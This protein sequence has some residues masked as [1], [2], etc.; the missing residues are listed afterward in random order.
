MNVTLSLGIG[1]P[2]T[3]HLAL[4][5][6]TPSNSFPPLDLGGHLG[7]AKNDKSLH[8]TLHSFVLMS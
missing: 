8:F 3:N 1:I 4:K 2:F 6:M 5:T 7:S